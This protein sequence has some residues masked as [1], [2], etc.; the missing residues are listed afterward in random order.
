[1]QGSH[2]GG[3]GQFGSSSGQKSP[4]QLIFL[5][6]LEK[7]VMSGIFS[8]SKSQKRLSYIDRLVPYLP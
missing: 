3:F 8:E 7:D 2:S 6:D 5:L 4:R 1:M